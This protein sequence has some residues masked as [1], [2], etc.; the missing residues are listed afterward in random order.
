MSKGEKEGEFEMFGTDS[1]LI[2]CREESDW[3]NAE[4]S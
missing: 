2:K 3:S 4:E 1:N